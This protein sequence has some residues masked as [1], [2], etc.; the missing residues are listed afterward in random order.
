MTYYLK[1]RSTNFDEIDIE[2]VRTTLEKLFSGKKYPHALLFAG[3]KGT[4]KTSA[5]RIVAKV[6]NCEKPRKNTNPCDKCTQCTGIIRGTNIDVIE[7]DAAS[8]RGIDDIRALRE[9]V[10]L[11]PVAA[12]KKVYIIDEAHMLTTEASNAFLKTLE[13]PPDHVL[14]IFATTNPEKLIDTIRSRTTLVNFRKANVNEIVRSLKRIA[15]AEKLK[16]DKEA[17][18][19]V[20]GKSDGSFRDA[21]KTLEHLS[22]F[23]RKITGNNIEELLED[24][25]V[26]DTEQFLELLSHKNTKDCLKVVQ[27]S[28]EI[29][30]DAKSMYTKS[31]DRLRSSLMYKNGLSGDDLDFFDIA[32]TI[33]LIDILSDAYSKSASAYIETI[34][35]E[36]V[37]S[38]WCTS[39]T[40]PEKPDTGVKKKNIDARVTGERSQPAKP[41]SIQESLKD[42]D[43]KVWKQVRDKVR[44]VNFALDALLR[45][46]KPLGTAGNKIKLGV[47][48]T[49]HKEHLEREAN[50]R[51]L[52]DVISDIFGYQV[53]VDCVLCEPDKK[54]VSGG[55]VLQEPKSTLTNGDEGDIMKAAKEI[56][57]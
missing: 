21:I 55:A 20:A 32:E 13:E 16:I 36:I 14:F 12:N 19:T 53:I 48:Y 9:A 37:I 26:F 18:E 56:F 31:I 49:F 6:L 22:T 28:N 38:R 27:K 8:H 3:P 1:Y 50:R 25:G 41:N 23:R 51:A 29:G 10:K 4:G 7:L 42:I 45:A 33:E 15:K 30:I 17:L 5:A 44:S 11:S 47:Y 40:A 39:T 35:L 57:G 52:E 2:S 54:S 34:P 43:T 24:S 46:S